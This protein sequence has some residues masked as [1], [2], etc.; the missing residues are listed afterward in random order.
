MVEIKKSSF[1]KVSTFLTEM[2][3][4]GYIEIKEEKKGIE[5]ITELKVDNLPLFKVRIHFEGVRCCPRLSIKALR[6]IEMTPFHRF[7]R[8]SSPKSKT[9]QP[10]PRMHSHIRC[11]KFDKCSW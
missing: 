1:K 5:H 2:K 9:L 11:R 8:N 4:L 6:S 7:G 3:A 10:I